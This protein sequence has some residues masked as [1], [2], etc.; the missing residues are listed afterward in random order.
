MGRPPKTLS[1]E[2]LEIRQAKRKEQNRLAQIRLRLRKR[3][4]DPNACGAPKSLRAVASTVKADKTLT[5]LQL[6]HNKA[7]QKPIDPLRPREDSVALEPTEPL[8][9]SLP[10]AVPPLFPYPRSENTRTST[11]SLPLVSKPPLNVAPL[12]YSPFGPPLHDPVSKLGTLSQPSDWHS[13]L[14]QLNNGSSTMNEGIKSSVWDATNYLP[15]PASAEV[16]V[17]PKLHEDD[18][19][20]DRVSQDTTPGQP[21]IR[22][23]QKDKYRRGMAAFYA[24][25]AD[26][27]KHGDKELEEGESFAVTNRWTSDHKSST[28]T[29]KGKESSNVLSDF[30][31][32]LNGSTTA[33]QSY[34]S[35]GTEDLLTATADGV[36]QATTSNASQAL[37][38]CQLSSRTVGPDRIWSPNDFWPSTYTFSATGSLRL[39]PSFPVEH[40]FYCVGEI[41]GVDLTI[42]DDDQQLSHLA[43]N[44]AQY[45]TIRA[46]AAPDSGEPGLN[47]ALSV[48]P[49]P[50]K[51]APGSRQPRPQGLLQWE[52]MPSILRPSKLAAQV[53][54]HFFI[55]ACFPWP[56]VRDR[57]LE[58]MRDGRFTQN[59]LCMDMWAVE[60]TNA[61][62]AAYIVHGDNLFDPDAYEPSERFLQ[63]WGFLFPRTFLGSHAPPLDGG[64]SRG[65]RGW[66][67]DGLC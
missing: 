49:N 8:L 36:R 46:G 57:V 29:P 63:K 52:R 1:S 21:I 15:P 61:W 50:S 40:V 25:L 43:E 54:H 47:T 39:L 16:A 12:L 11:S 59:E 48:S 41:L 10:P 35:K 22:S 44:Y 17:L 5:S 18:S 24:T 64:F 38:A 53:P 60:S 34:S 7:P 20:A 58:H 4:F 6:G 45:C 9:A 56:S 28:T 65:D 3:G 19:P 31:A 23:G 2:E 66:I 67:A 30:L 32:S 62:D 37:S 27:L 55:D 51:W 33:L 13:L 26:E 42:W 14:P